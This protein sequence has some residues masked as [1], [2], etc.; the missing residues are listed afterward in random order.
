MGCIAELQ[1]PKID[2]FCAVVVADVRFFVTTTILFDIPGWDQIWDPPSL[3]GPLLP[4]FGCEDDSP[5]DRTREHPLESERGM[6][7]VRVRVHSQEHEPGWER[8]GMGLSSA[9][10][11]ISGLLST[12]F[13]LHRTRNC[14]RARGEMGRSEWLILICCVYELYCDYYGIT[15]LWC[16]KL[17]ECIYIPYNI[18]KIHSNLS[19]WNQV[20]P[21]IDMFSLG[22]VVCAVHRGGK[23]L[24]ESSGDVDTFKRHAV[25]LSSLT[26][27]NLGFIPAP[28]RDTIHLLLNQDPQL[29]PDPPQVGFQV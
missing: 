22:S 12:Q 2:F 15:K 5:R 28:L 13:W 8:P 19:I 23:P 7:A 26:T 24:F 17:G 14:T 10:E 16:K 27:G 6:E 25:Q 18:I 1:L 9:G 11:R 29:R 21:S 20:T 3:R 4:P